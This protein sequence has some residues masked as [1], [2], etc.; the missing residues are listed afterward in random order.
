[1]NVTS[2]S[3]M[4]QLT[5]DSLG[6]WKIADSALIVATCEPPPTAG[7]C[8]IDPNM[9]EAMSNSTSETVRA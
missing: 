2:Q 4:P 8:T 6:T 1:M 3:N 9:L 7:N 5:A